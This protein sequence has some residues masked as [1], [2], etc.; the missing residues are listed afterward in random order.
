MEEPGWG[1]GEAVG[2]GSGV[3]DGDGDGERT[4]DGDEAGG[5]DIVGVRVGTTV[6][7]AGPSSSGG[8]KRKPATTRAAV[9]RTAMRISGMD[10]PRFGRV[11]GAHW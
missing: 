6:G 3:A 9:P 7:C 11:S 2:V 5:V 8:M 4:G 1:A 10:T